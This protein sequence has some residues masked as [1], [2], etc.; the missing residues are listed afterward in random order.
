MMQ[1]ID[2]EKDE[3]IQHVTDPVLDDTEQITVITSQYD[4]STY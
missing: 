1:H 4:E 2:E 3:E